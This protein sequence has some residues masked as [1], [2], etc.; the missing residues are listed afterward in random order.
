M[1]TGHKDVVPALLYGLRDLTVMCLVLG[2]GVGVSVG[3]YDS[4]PISS[5]NS[6]QVFYIY[7]Y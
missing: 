2:A 7:I 3:T 6:Q 5:S 1:A 4:Y